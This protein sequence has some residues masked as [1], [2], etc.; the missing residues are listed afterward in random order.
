ME[1]I[2][3]ILLVGFALFFLRRALVGFRRGV[4]TFS[5]PGYSLTARRG[6]DPVGFPVALWGNVF[7]CVV[8]LGTAAWLAFLPH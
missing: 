1:L 8:L 6:D 3:A 2:F 7:K 5:V 4:A